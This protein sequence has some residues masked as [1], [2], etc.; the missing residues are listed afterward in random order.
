MR[1]SDVVGHSDAAAL[2]DR[3][4]ETQRLGSAYLLV[5][6]PGI[7]K[8]RLA[9]AFAARLLCASP[10]NGDSC[11]ACAHCT[12]VASGV[13]PDVRIVE[14]EPERRDIRIEQARELCRWLSL[15]PLMAARK[16]AVIDGAEQLNEHGQN[17]LLK[18]L[19]E[20]PGASV[21]ILTANAATLLLPTVRSRCQRIRL[22]PLPAAAVRDILLASG[23]DAADAT[24]LVAQADGSPGR[25]LAL[26]DGPY[27]KA[28][29]AL[30]GVLSDLRNRA[31][32]EL[33]A[34]AQE[35]A[36]GPTEAGLGA[37][38]AWY[39]DVV[40]LVVD[41]AASPRRNPDHADA[42]RTVAARLTL[43]AALRQLRTVC[44]T[45]EDI[46]HNANRQLALET[47]LLRLR[48]IER[49][50]PEAESW[51]IRR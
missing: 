1:F 46:E 44:A 35:I 41:P 11:G 19:E 24:W 4:I 26:A 16:V 50:D 49:G 27:A 9:D 23:V 22:D 12:R 38:L 13:H 2:L 5:G 48:A 32:H 42:I 45:V 8:R 15:R 30:A 18:T 36:R 20:P 51:T 43:D 10:V 7:G 25:G 17:A 28:R 21:L 37:A 40:G 31:A 34:V 6:P 33:S 39:R 47:L 3:S 14:R 29:A